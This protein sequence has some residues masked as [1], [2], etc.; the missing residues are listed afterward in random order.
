MPGTRWLAVPARIGMIAFA[1]SALAWAIVVFPTFWL[2]AP[3]IRISGRIVAGEP[4]KTEALADVMPVVGEAETAT[5]CRP[6][7]LRSAAIIRLRLAEQA[8]AAPEAPQIDQP[9]DSLHDAIDRSLACAPADPFLWVVLFW[10]ENTRSGFSADHL[11]FLRQ[12]YRL[13]PNEGWIAL[14]RNRF[15]LALYSQLPPDLQGTAVDEFVQLLD[16]GF[17]DETAATLTGPGWPLR[18]IL[19]PRLKE[20]DIRRREV[21]AKLLRRQDYDVDIPGVARPVR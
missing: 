12:S 5:L 4:F 6:A 21:F 15:A 14:R 8:V 18:G 9:L 13:G 7:A 1:L 11:E 2:Q 17:Y 10:L 19:L 3:I 16:S 20:V